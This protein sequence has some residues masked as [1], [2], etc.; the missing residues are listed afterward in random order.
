[1]ASFKAEYKPKAT[2]PD[3]PILV[4]RN[5]S[6][7]RISVREAKVLIGELTLAIVEAGGY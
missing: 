4:G 7:A 6:Q 1:M 3:K 2:K 5:Q